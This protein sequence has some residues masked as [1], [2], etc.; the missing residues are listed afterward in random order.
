MQ[1]SK[2]SHQ[3]P[4]IRKL[5]LGNKIPW[6]LLYINKS[7]LGVGAISQRSETDILDIKSYIG[8]RMKLI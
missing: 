6:K 3:L 7:A 4:I 8:N 1:E 5:G 2:L